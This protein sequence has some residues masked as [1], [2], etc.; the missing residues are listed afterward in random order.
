MRVLGELGVDI[1]ITNS[2]KIN[3]LHLAVLKN[4]VQIA[5]MLCKSNFPID[6]ET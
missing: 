4:H 6:H 5:K 3:V 1:F 2:N